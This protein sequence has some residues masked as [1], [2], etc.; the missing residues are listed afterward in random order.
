MADLKEEFEKLNPGKI[1][2]EM[3]G[4]ALENHF[5]FILKKE[6]KEGVKKVEE[7]LAQLGYPLKYEEI[8]NFQWYPRIMDEAI[9]FVIKRVLGWEDEV[10]RE[11]GRWG[12]KVS[13]ITRIMMKYFLSI[14][15]VFREVS[16][17]WRKYYTIGKLEPVEI[18]LKE[19][20]LILELKDL[21]IIC[22]EHCRYWEGYFW[23]VG[24]YVLPKEDLKL[25]ETDCIFRGSNAHR[26]KATW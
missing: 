8:K 19:R 21:P 16:N 1:K 5:S 15:R 25:W 12:A 9:Y 20:Y 26:F 7:G 22:P 10:F 4:L 2:G 3:I 18:N 17:Y 6:G 11:S 23:Q 14:E 24:A 13:Y